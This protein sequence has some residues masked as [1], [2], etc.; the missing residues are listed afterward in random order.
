[1]NELDLNSSKPP[2]NNNHHIHNHHFTANPWYN[3]RADYNTNAPSYYDYLARYNMSEELIKEI[4]N[5]LLRRNIEVIDTNSIDLTKEGDWI[6]N[7]TCDNGTGI[8]PNNYDDIIKLQA[9]VIVS[10]LIKEIQL[11]SLSDITFELNNSITKETDGIYSPDFTNV[12]RAYD[13]KITEIM[14]IIDEIINS[15]NGGGDTHTLEVPRIIDISD[16]NL[17]INEV[18][19]GPVDDNTRV[20]IEWIMGSTIG[21]QICTVGDLKGKNAHIMSSNMV[22][23]SNE[24]DFQETWTHVVK[25]NKLWTTAI[26]KARVNKD[27]RFIWDSVPYDEN[28]NPY[29][30][31][32][33]PKLKSDPSISD[34]TFR[35]LT[36]YDKID[37]NAI[38]RGRLKYGR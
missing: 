21:T 33:D 19:L 14:N 1:M 6:D 34:V 4:I 28:N 38:M 9:D 11:P 32:Q 35:K 25:N 7:G 31:K 23:N 15:I 30:D 27:G 36:V 26:H 17:C 16:N 37:I 24:L 12:L 5:R 13:N 20:E 2:Y 3:D 10:K 22:D 8:L 18:D 29:Y